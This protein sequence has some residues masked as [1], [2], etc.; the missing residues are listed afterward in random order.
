MTILELVNIS[1]SFGGVRAADNVSL[2]FGNGKITC[3]IG[4]N[5]A[6]KT[7][8]FNIITGFLRPDAGSVL[9]CGKDITNLNPWQVA[10][11]GVGRLFQD[12]RAFNRMTVLDNVLM[13]F[14]RQIGES[15][16]MSVLIPWKVASEERA[17]I[18]RAGSLLEF[19]GLTENANDLSEVLSYGQQK[20]LVIARLLAADHD[21]LLLDEPT[22]G[23][24]PQYVKVL[25]DLIR[26][27][28]RRGK[29]VVIIEH[30]MNVV[31]EVADWVYFLD[32]GQVTSFGMPSEVLADPDVR[33][34]YVGL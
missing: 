20:L 32:R 31:I 27:L 15:A 21:V 11:R 25:L 5:G 23:V 10:R 30:N 18:E 26:R 28:A 24:N 29:T 8:L 17:L 1:K 14:K 22:A 16:L 9:Y 13:A 6:G 19:V 7:T 12:V 3:L 34:A 4:P 2:G 33:T